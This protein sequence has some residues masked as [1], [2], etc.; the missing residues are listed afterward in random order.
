[1]LLVKVPEYL[2]ANVDS[3]IGSSCS[4]DL[5]DYSLLSMF[6]S[7]ST[8]LVCC[9]SQLLPS[10]SLDSS[11]DSIKKMVASLLALALL[12]SKSDYYCTDCED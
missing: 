5:S 2:I 10:L 4:D 6:P 1:M 3:G 11:V 7:P 12:E 8:F 9:S